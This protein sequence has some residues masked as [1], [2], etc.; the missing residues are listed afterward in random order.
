MWFNLCAA[1]EMEAVALMVAV[2]GCKIQHLGPLSHLRHGC[3][4]LCAVVNGS[5]F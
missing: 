4:Q 5:N 1:A 3:A 2:G